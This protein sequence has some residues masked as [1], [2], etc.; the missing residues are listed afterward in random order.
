VTASVVGSRSVRLGRPVRLRFTLSA[1]AR[2]ALEVR[3]ARGRAQ[4]ISF[5]RRQAG[6][7]V[8]KWSG[9]LRGRRVAGRYTL[10]LVATAD[11][12]VR[13]DTVRVRLRR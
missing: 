2:L 6:R 1:P 10:V 12:T 11:G 7:G 8:I 9:K 13:R 3:P 4:R 5:G